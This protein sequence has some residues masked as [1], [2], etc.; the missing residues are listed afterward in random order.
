MAL[1]AQQQQTQLQSLLRGSQ[2]RTP[3]MVH[4]K[5]LFPKLP[6]HNVL[7]HRSWQTDVEVPVADW[8]NQRLPQL[9]QGRQC[10]NHMSHHPHLHRQLILSQ[11]PDSAWNNSCCGGIAWIA[12]VG[13]LLPCLLSLRRT[14]RTDL[15]PEHWMECLPLHLS[16]FFLPLPWQHCAWH[17]LARHHSQA[18]TASAPLQHTE[19][20]RVYCCVPNQATLPS[21]ERHFPRWQAHGGS[22]TGPTLPSS[23]RRAIPIHGGTQAQRCAGRSHVVAR[24]LPVV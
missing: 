13:P 1:S 24:D 5:S 6:K 21:N 18:A 7:T 15:P 9:M 19:A 12:L 23:P 16:G 8:S 14:H 2:A 17:Q 3:P 22:T 20:P 4:H 11:D 10:P